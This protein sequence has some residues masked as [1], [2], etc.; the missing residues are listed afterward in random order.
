[1][2]KY[3]SLV[4]RCINAKSTMMVIRDIITRKTVAMEAFFVEIFTV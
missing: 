3:K 2:R 1:M 4:F